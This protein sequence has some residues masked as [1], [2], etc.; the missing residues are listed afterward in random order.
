MKRRGPDVA[1]AT[2]AASTVADAAAD[3]ITA[4]KSSR[5]AAASAREALSR[6][7][8]FESAGEAAFASAA[9]AA[10]PPSGGSLT[11][12]NSA[13]A[14]A[15]N[16]GE[17]KGPP[18]APTITVRFGDKPDADLYTKAVPKRDASGRV[19]FPDAPE[20]RPTMS[21]EEVLRAGAFGGTYF[22]PIYSSVAKARFVGAWR[23]FPK[24]WTAGLDAPKMLESSHYDTKVNKFRVACGQSLA[25]W[26][27]SG[28]IIA[29]D[30]FG[31][32]QWYCRFYLGRRCDDDERQIGRWL[33]CAGPTGRWKNNLIAK[34]VAAGK[35]HNDASVAPVV[36]QTLLHWAYE[37]TEEDF[38]A[39]AKRMSGGA[40]AAY[41]RAPG[42]LELAAAAAVSKATAAAGG[43]SKSVSKGKAGA[44]KDAPAAGGAGRAAAAKAKDDADDDDGDDDD[45]AASAPPASKR[46]KGKGKAA[47]SK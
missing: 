45:A 8:A 44:S 4:R 47:A 23:E 42:G 21:P 10:A 16:A 19:H 38:L 31:W 34:C 32:F 46:Q 2:A 5:A 37:L 43:K 27:S 12:S 1:S 41:Y 24:E 40:K 15:I 9:A 35:A 11:A 22:R 25:A 7:A 13:A 28:W 33:A 14:S 36:R 18:G 30:P 39:Y 17:P 20:F 26:E 3:S 29:R 6:V